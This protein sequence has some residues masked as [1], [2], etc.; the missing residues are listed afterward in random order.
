MMGHGV[1]HLWT[2]VLRGVGTAPGDSR[3][4]RASCQ[5]TS[6][7]RTRASRSEPVAAGHG[8]AAGGTDPRAMALTRVRLARRVSVQRHEHV[9][10]EQPWSDPQ[11]ARVAEGSASTMFPV[12][13][14]PVNSSV[15]PNS[16]SGATAKL[17]EEVI[18]V[19]S[20]VT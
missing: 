11:Q 20:A 13:L 14:A 15:I 5:R 10:G 9:I 6:C 2:V 7:P 12:E 4:P 19:P 18:T 8:L 3:H 16:G 1:A 17:S